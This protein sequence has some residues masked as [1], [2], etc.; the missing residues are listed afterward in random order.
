MRGLIFASVLALTFG[1][2]SAA[3]ETISSAEP[4]QLPAITWQG[5]GCK[6]E[7]LAVLMGCPFDQASPFVMRVRLEK[8]L[9]LPSHSYPVDI[10][11][12]ML[13]GVLDITLSKDTKSA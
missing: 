13:S 8:G 6:G 12:T 10:G 11:V 2:T 1:L 5:T 3:Q 7:E 9:H 4:V